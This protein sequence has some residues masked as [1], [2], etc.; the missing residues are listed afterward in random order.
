MG[1]PCVRGTSSTRI[2]RLL[3]LASPGTSFFLGIE[4]TE[5]YVAKKRRGGRLRGREPA[6]RPGA[7]TIRLTHPDGPFPNVLAMVFAPPVPSSTPCW[8]R[9][10]SPPPGV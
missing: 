8:N 5:Q 9:A 4:G 7:I 2:E 1:R 3:A 6:D 10:A